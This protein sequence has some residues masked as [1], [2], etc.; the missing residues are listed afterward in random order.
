M[1]QAGTCFCGLIMFVESPFNQNCVL[2]P[3][4]KLRRTDILA[5]F[6]LVSKHDTCCMLWNK[7]QISLNIMTMVS[8]AQ[9][10]ERGKALFLF[11]IAPLAVYHYSSFNAAIRNSKGS[12]I[13]LQC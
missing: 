10:S 1:N 6:S 2:V 5:N 8:I 3:T 12:F 7:E 13:L 4:V 11:L 9:C